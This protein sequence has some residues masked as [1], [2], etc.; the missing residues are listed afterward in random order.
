MRLAPV[1]GLLALLA[2]SLLPASSSG[3]SL[4]GNGETCPNEALRK[5]Q[6]SQLADCRAYELVS[7]TDKNGGDIVGDGQT[8][9]SSVDGDAVTFSSRASFG[10]TRGSGALGQTQYMAR[11]GAGG[12]TTHAITPTPARDSFQVLFG[13]TLMPWFSEDLSKVVF[14]AYD[15]PG[16]T[17]D[18]PNEVNV[19]REDTRTDAIETITKGNLDPVSPFEILLSGAEWGV[20]G[21][22]SHVAFMSSSRYS[23]EAVAGVPNVYDWSDGTVRLAGVLPDGSAPEAGSEMGPHFYRGTVS[24]DGSRFVFSSGGQIYLRSDGS[25]TAW[26]SQGEASVEVPA[27]A[28]VS[29]QGVSRDGKHVVFATSSR[30]LDSDTNDGLDL[31]LYTDSASPATEANLTQ[32]TNSGAVDPSTGGLAVVGMSDDASTIYFQEGTNGKLFVWHDGALHL[33]SSNVSRQ[34]GGG[35]GT[36]LGLDASDPGYG[37]VSRNG[38]TMAFLASSTL[39]N[40]GA[41][42]LSG[43]DHV[44][45][46]HTEMYVYSAADDRLTCVS[47]PPGGR[48][49]SADATVLPAATGGTSSLALPGDRPHFLS[50]D[51]T[52]VFFSTA[53][54]LVPQDT[55]G[56]ADVYEYDT[57]TGTTRL[58]STGAG[59]DGAWF[60]DASA[61][62]G[63]VFLVT[64]RQLLASDR[65]EL[66]DLYDARVDGGLPQV[67]TVAPTPCLDEVCQGSPSPAPAFQAPTGV[68]LAGSGNLKPVPEKVSRRQTLRQALRACKTQHK[69]AKRK[70]CEATARKRFAKSARSK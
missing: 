22:D 6:N 58:V 52:R 64:R 23:P 65:D 35:P 12:W 21:D 49:A 61:G 20:A 34:Q 28:E 41:H 43:A 66:V 44:T 70:K 59:P 10:D 8:T 3:S 36:D 24:A 45:N 69:K 9:I 11:R 53:D 39:N 7:P 40:D 37:R 38:S 48:A 15:L 55:N 50:D 60:A 47:C 56:L 26:V 46:G 67:A 1:A 57:T 51:G 30:L 19:Y 32:L 17:D 27:P 16:V 5:E 54:A 13:S 68:R 14:W 63:D 42:A 33:I 29:L 62:G 4:D 31:Y 25:R 2:V 18:Q